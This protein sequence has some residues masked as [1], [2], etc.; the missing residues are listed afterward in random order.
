MCEC[1]SYVELRWAGFA[2]DTMFC[3]PFLWAAPFPLTTLVEPVLPDE[4]GDPADVA[5]REVEVL[6][7]PVPRFPI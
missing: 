7:G 2:F 5:F 4:D 3:E 1:C 6:L